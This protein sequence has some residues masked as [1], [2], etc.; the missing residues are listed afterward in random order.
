MY[1]DFNIKN[2]KVIKKL[3][4]TNAV[5]LTGN[6]D[7]TK[8]IIPKRTILP[9]NDKDF[10]GLFIP[11]I[12]FQFILRFTK[13]N[14]IVWDCFGGSGTTKKVAD[15]LHRECIINDLN[16][17]HNYIKRGDSRKFNP[18]KN[19]Q[20]I[21]MHP[22]YWDIVKYS[23]Q[24]NDGSNQD[25][26]KN[27]LNWFEDVVDNVIQYLDKNRFLILVCGN[28]YKNSEELT[29]GVWCKDI[30]TKKGFKLKSHIIKDYGVTK[31][32]SRTYNLNYYRQLRGN[33][34]NFYGDNIFILQK[35]RNV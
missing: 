33:Y 24:E 25:T 29:L 30:I 27:Y 4:T 15:L 13:R 35:I 8:F 34:N 11:E 14:E 2:W 20:L 32:G 31:G 21:F 17:V 23:E 10:H 12:P 22:P 16:P 7:Q 5:W 1:N 26:L 19:V 6:K 18:K 28:I 9:K 3:I